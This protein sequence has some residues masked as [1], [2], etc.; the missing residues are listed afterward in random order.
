VER[1]VVLDASALIAFLA[2]EPGG[3]KV[4]PH[5]DGA[6]MSTA[7]VVE[8][9]D[10]IT[11]AGGS[12][13]DVEYFVRTLGLSIMDLDLH[14][15]LDAGELLQTTRSAGLSLGDRC[16]LALAK[17]LDRPALTADRSLGDLVDGGS[18]GHPDTLS[19]TRRCRLRVLPPAE[20]PPSATDNQAQGARAWPKFSSFITR[21]TVT[22]SSSPLRRR[23]VLGRQARR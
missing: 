3:D 20:T 12:R 8:V 19:A 7:N 2:E 4:A 16:C 18:R 5:L 14:L 9:S 1:E 10:F 6:A 22:S 23:R 11:R 21:P 17:R 15:A 13:L